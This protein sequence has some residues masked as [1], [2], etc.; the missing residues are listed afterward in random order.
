MNSTN[1]HDRLGEHVLVS[2]MDE[3]ELDLQE[4]VTPYVRDSRTGE[5]WLDF[6]SFY[7][8]SALGMNHPTLRG[9]QEFLDRLLN[10]AVNKPANSDF[11][12]R[13]FV[14]FVETFARVL[15]DPELPHYF[16]I[17]GGSAAVENALK[18]AFDWKQKRNR[19]LG[20]SADLGTQVLHLEHA[21]HGRGGYTLSLTNTDPVKVAGFPKFGWPRIPA[22]AQKY[23]LSPEAALEL[24]R[25]EETAVAAARS[26]FLAHP[27]DIACFIAEPIQGEGGDRHLRPRFLQ[28]L[29]GLCR[30]FDALFVLDEVQTGCGLTGSTW[31]YQ[32][33][34]LE[35]DIVV[36]GKKVQVCGLMAGRRV[37]L[38]E[39]NVFRVPSRINST[40]GGNLTDMVRARRILEVIETEDLVANAG[41]V[42]ER[43]LVGLRDLA[44]EF[45]DLVLN[46]RGRGLMCALSLPS[47]ALR[48]EVLAGLTDLRILVLGCG[49]N[50]IRFRPPL[51]V[52]NAA[53]DSA[54][55]AL[56]SVL[57]GLGPDRRA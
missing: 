39:D 36:F 7:A 27:G 32:Q 51:C 15:G 26:C 1:L 35:P 22:P 52:D 19:D 41:K 49:E 34:G 38:V 28:A 17:E 16:F 46:P 48:N 54:L 12:S 5:D 56:R 14:E 18:V 10:T 6:G 31:A 40:W 29:Q 23:P 47:L 20:L 45:P 44:G 43:L 53:V 9:D 24:D 4:S 50:S 37:D 13:E 30:E 25:A 8:S 11:V 33:L 3:I 2:G 57:V 21:F 42:G 55:T